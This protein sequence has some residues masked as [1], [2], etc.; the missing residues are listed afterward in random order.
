LELVV[1]C[2]I[3]GD[4]FVVFTVEVVNYDEFKMGG[5]HQ[6]HI[7]ATWK[8]RTISEFVLRQEETK[9]TCIDVA[10]RRIFRVH[11]NI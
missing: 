3:W 11:T 8:L 7:L 4:N 2:I 9:E 10:G 1:G 6:K 5:L